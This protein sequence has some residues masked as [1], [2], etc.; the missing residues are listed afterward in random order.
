MD[1]SAPF[2]D[3]V[4]L[5]LNADGTA[6]FSSASD[7]ED[8]KCTWEETG[9]GLKLKGDAKMTFTD[10]G[11]GLITDEIAQATELLGELRDRSDLQRMTDRIAAMIG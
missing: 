7:G 6:V 1:E 5:V 8:S 4:L 2:E 11:D 9:D 10:D 3:E